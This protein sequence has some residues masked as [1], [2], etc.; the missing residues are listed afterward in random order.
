MTDNDSFHW[1]EVLRRHHFNYRLDGRDVYNELI[2]LIRSAADGAFGITDAANCRHRFQEMAV[3]QLRELP[4]GYLY[5]CMKISG[6]DFQIHLPPAVAQNLVR[7]IVRESEKDIIYGWYDPE[8]KGVNV[9]AY[10][11][12][13]E[14]EEN[15]S[16]AYDGY[17]RYDTYYQIVEGILA[18]DGN[19][20]LAEP[21]L[22]SVGLY[23]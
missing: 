2:D 8:T 16:P 1:C 20:W 22:R 3:L 9:L 15:T 5:R 10:T 18:P 6:K 21:R 17:G 11:G 14:E 7:H 12:R 13:L 19:S 23:G 4:W